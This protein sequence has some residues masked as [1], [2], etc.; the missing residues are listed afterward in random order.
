MVD[1]CIQG[2]PDKATCMLAC[3]AD[4]GRCSCSCTADLERLMTGSADVQ[5]TLKEFKITFYREEHMGNLSGGLRQLSSP[6]GDLLLVSSSSS[7]ATGPSNVT[8]RRLEIPRAP[9]T[10]TG[11]AYGPIWAPCIL[12]LAAAGPLRMHIC[13][14]TADFVNGGTILKIAADRTV[15]PVS[16]LTP[17][18]KVAANAR[19]LGALRSMAWSLQS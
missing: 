3:S 7:T 12:K 14:R 4:G 18:R 11:N 5:T 10:C 9:A 19:G 6:I 17:D 2:S 15:Q 8:I 16:C 13:L 1:L